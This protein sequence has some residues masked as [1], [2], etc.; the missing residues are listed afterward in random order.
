ML[1]I[2]DHLFRYQSEHWTLNSLPL[3]FVISATSEY[4]YMSYAQKVQLGPGTQEQLLLYK[5]IKICLMRG[6]F[7]LERGENESRLWSI[8]GDGAWRQI[9]IK[10]FTLHSLHSLL[11]RYRCQRD[12]WES[13]QRDTPLTHWSCNNR[14]SFQTSATINIQGDFFSHYNST[15][16]LLKVGCI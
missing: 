12:T 11:N 1:V 6:T 16:K 3:I 2:S 7:A 9:R 8:W 15:K 5:I 10:L 4:I 14:Y 13:F